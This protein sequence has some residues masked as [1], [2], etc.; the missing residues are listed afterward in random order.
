MRLGM[1]AAAAT[2]VPGLALAHG[3]AAIT[4]C[5]SQGLGSWLL[6]VWLL[7]VAPSISSCKYVLNAFVCFELARL[8]GPV[9]GE[10]TSVH[11]LEFAGFAGF[12]RQRGRNCGHEYKLEA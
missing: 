10:G 3:A 7:A 8:C 11:V 5:E 2:H 4:R 9:C 1:R 12:T 6:G